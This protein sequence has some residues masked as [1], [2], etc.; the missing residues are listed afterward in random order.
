MPSLRD[1]RVVKVFQR[2]FGGRLFFLEAAILLTI[3]SI[4]FF[5]RILPIRWGLYLS[6]FD[7]WMQYK[8]FLFIVKRGW[9]GFIEFFSW[10]DTSS[11]Y[12]FG[13]DVGKTAFPGLP[14]LAAFIYHIL[15][16][17]GINVRPLELAAFIPPIFGIIST[18]AAYLLG[19][20]LGGK[21]AGFFSAFFMALSN[22]NIGRTHMGWFD[23]ESISI[24]LMLLGLWAYI[25]AIKEN[26][27]RRGLI[28]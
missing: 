16:G 21:P 11:W 15:H 1:S 14:F 22:A 24:P 2:F 10:H 25:E 17:I 12:P 6:E 8:E 27:S 19:R 28:A 3:L 5:V 23:D 18:L 13:R 7:P 26:R 9:S 20:E 4:A